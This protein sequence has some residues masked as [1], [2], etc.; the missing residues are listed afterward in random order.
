MCR[1]AVLI[2]ERTARVPILHTEFEQR[3]EN[4]HFLGAEPEVLAKTIA[5]SRSPYH[6]RHEAVWESSVVGSWIH[7]Y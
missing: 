6:R 1:I 5:M 7:V 3:E 2:S 4:E